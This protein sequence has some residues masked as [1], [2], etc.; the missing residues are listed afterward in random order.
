MEH[1]NP[2]HSSENDAEWEIPQIGNEEPRMFD[3]TRTYDDGEFLEV[4][5]EMLGSLL[6]R[7]DASEL[8]E[9]I[10]ILENWEKQVIDLKATN[11][12]PSVKYLI[13]FRHDPDGLIRLSKSV[14][15]DNVGDSPS[16]N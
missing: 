6:A 10:Y 3:M 12:D 1:L 11:D 2:N 13:S 7:T 5:R 4:L 9:V 8:S 15:L 14:Y 16:L